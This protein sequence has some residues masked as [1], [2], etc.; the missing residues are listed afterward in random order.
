V[1]IQYK[2]Q[3]KAT[4]T[5]T[6]EVALSHF[7]SK[8]QFETDPSDVH[9]DME[10]GMADFVLV[11]V[12]SAKDYADGHIPGAV[13]I[14]HAQIT[15]ERIASA[16]PADALF[17]VYCWGPGCNGSTKGAAHFSELGYATKE[18]IGG[19]EYWRHEGYAIEG[20]S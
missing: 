13:N 9:F 5:S 2:S 17:V 12:R 4:P 8:L 20:K 10:H 14:P 19:I 11:D 18:L 16:Y 6:S 3:V 7:Q 15:Q 1:A